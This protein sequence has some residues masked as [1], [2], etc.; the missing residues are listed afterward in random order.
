ML[1]L[2][3]SINPMKNQYS[4]CLYRRTLLWVVIHICFCILCNNFRN[5]MHIFE[6]IELV[7]TEIGIFLFKIAIFTASQTNSFNVSIKK[8]QNFFVMEKKCNLVL[9]TNLVSRECKSKFKVNF[10]GI[11]CV[12]GNI[13]IYKSSRK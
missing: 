11:I 5:L 2:F 13:Y 8:Y 1:S 3:I 10:Y 4:V 12:F 6:F 9:Y 7:F